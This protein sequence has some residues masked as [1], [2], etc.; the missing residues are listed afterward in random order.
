MHNFKLWFHTITFGETKHFIKL[1]LWSFLDSFILTIPYSVMMISI[2]LLLM[3][4]ASP[5]HPLPM[6]QLWLMIGILLVQSALAFFVR[7]KTYIDLC[8]GFA[9]TTKK[10]R[11]SMGQ[12]LKNLSMGF[13]SKRDAGDLSTVLLRDY[14]EVEGLASGIVPQISV[15]LIRLLLSILVFSAIDWRMMLAVMLVIPLALPFAIISYHRMGT[16]SNELLQI[17]QTVASQTL[18]YISGIQTLKAYNLAGEHFDSL[19]QT[20]EN[21]RKSSIMMESAAAPIAVIGRFI[22][23]CGIGVVMSVGAWLT[24]KGDLSPFFYLVFLLIALNIYNPIMTIFSFIAD[25]SRTNRSA[26]RIYELNHEK[27][28]PEIE[29]DCHPKNMDI[30]FNDVSFSYGENEV[31]HNISM[32]IPAK[33][34]TALV[35]HSGSGKSTIL[36]LISR[37]WDVDKGEISLGTVPLTHMKTDTLL[38]QISMVFQDVYLFHDTIEEN[39]RMGKPNATHAEIETAAKM[40][41]CHDFIVS[42]PKGYG[43]IV[44]EGGSTLS[45]GEKQRI[46]IAR[47]LLKNAPIVLLDEATASLDPENEVLIQQAISALVT[48]KTVIVIAHR[49][50][51]INNADQIVVLDKGAVA[52]LGTHEE[53]LSTNGIYASLWEEQSH[54]GRWNLINSSASKNL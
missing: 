10:A 23:N 9:H 2:Y 51:S 34:L 8:I 49:L 46:S 24:I 37:F 35:G 41:S 31:L 43:T 38:S 6:K 17:Q 11:I 29:E 42:L 15:I 40:A 5:S 28:L 18:E 32:N 39:I 7:K 4:I 1:C 50:Q 54:A 12:H 14:T 52:E 20:F 22:L 27:A 3:P 21:Q 48:N 53:L 44:G 26:E 19:K 47:A 33:S 36:K 25:Y 13:Y 30:V 45:G 16:V